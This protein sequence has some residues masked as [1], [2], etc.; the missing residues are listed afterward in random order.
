M[1]NKQPLIALLLG[2]CLI[3]TGAT[4]KE[5]TPQAR[6]TFTKDVLPILRVLVRREGLCDLVVIFVGG[7]RRRGT[8][9]VIVGVLAAEVLR[10][11]SSKREQVLV[12]QRGGLLNRADHFRA[13]AER[14]AR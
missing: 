9:L 11:G 3:T 14:I 6:V 2:I 1:K 10:E 5:T 7:A 8:E 12:K 4:A 13:T